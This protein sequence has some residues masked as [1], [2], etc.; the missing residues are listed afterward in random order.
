MALFPWQ[1]EALRRGGPPGLG[2]ALFAFLLLAGIGCGLG[3]IVWSS[4][5]LVSDGR[6]RQ[7][8]V[9]DGIVGPQDWVEGWIDVTGDG[10]GRDGCL[11]ADNVLVRWHDRVRTAAVALPGADVARDGSDLVVSAV[12]EAVRCPVGLGPQAEAFGALLTLRSQTPAPR[13]GPVEPTDPRLR[14]HL[15]LDD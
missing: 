6:A 9:D 10:S 15:G 12:G 7:A 14:R 4:A 13:R 2:L 3:G 11:V 1:R 8:F 5:W